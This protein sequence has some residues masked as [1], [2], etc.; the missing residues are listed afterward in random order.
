MDTFSLALSVG[1]VLK[2]DKIIICSLTVG[3]FHFIMPL[4][5]YY[6]SLSFKN[7]KLINYDILSSCIF[8]YIGYTMFKDFLDYK[9]HNIEYNLYYIILFAI[10]VSLDSFGVGMTLQIN[11]IHY[12]IFS[13]FSFSFTMLGFKFGKLLNKKI[14]KYSILIGSIIMLSIAI[15]NLCKL[16]VL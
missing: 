1:T 5:G 7:L 10:G 15:V 16:I 4:L 14:G 8:I 12:L 2:Y 13:F 3:L 6:I 11:L 9:E